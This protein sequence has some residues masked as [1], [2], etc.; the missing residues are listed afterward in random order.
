VTGSVGPGAPRVTATRSMHS[1]S[2]ARG[3]ASRLPSPRCS[4]ASRTSSYDCSS[5]AAMPSSKLA[6]ARRSRSPPCWAYRTTRSPGPSSSRLA[7]WISGS[8]G[9]GSGPARRATPS[10][11]AGLPG[12]DTDGGSDR[13]HPLQSENG[14]RDRLFGN[15]LALRA[16]RGLSCDAGGARQLSFR[17]RQGEG[18]FARARASQLHGR[19]RDE[20]PIRAPRARDAARGR[21]GERGRSQLLEKSALCARNEHERR[22]IEERIARLLKTKP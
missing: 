19:R 15:R 4:E 17:R 11:G 20:L 18:P 6:R 13:C 1:R 3:R 16:P 14:G 2:S 5:P 9:L 8:R 7:A 22:Q 21:G 10:S 12:S